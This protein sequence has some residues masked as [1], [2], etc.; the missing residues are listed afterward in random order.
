M[1]K[2]KERKR[3]NL[4]ELRETQSCRT[5]REA[6]FSLFFVN[7]ASKRSPI[8]WAPSQGQP[9]WPAWELAKLPTVTVLVSDTDTGK[10]AVERDVP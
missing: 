10:G 4:I 9:G 8:C 6:S 3:L 2:M 7:E 1:V 5:F